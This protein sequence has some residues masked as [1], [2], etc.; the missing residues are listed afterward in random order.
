MRTST[1]A[2][3]NPGNPFGVN[4]LTYH[5]DNLLNLRLSKETPGNSMNEPKPTCPRCGSPMWLVVAENSA[6]G[7]ASHFECL[8]HVDDQPAEQDSG[9]LKITGAPRSL[10]G[11]I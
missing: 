5:R 7:A 6:D 10:M 2:P 11:P 3:H 1:A 8:F 4:C 9:D